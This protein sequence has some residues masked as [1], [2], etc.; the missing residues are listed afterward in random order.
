MRIFSF[1]S[2]EA[3][4]DPFLHFFLCITKQGRAANAAR[5]CWRECL[6]LQVLRKVG[7]D[8]RH[9]RAGGGA[10]GIQNV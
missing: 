6:L 2:M 8:L 9:F 7:E 3:K 4:N 1:Q 10:G 5:P